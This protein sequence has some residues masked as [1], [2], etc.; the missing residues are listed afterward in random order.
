M[1]D[2][3]YYTENLFSNKPLNYRNRTVYFAFSFASLSAIM[4]VS[5]AP[6]SS[7]GE[8]RMG[9]KST[10]E[11]KNIYQISREEMNYSREAAAEKL[12]FLSSDRIEKIENEKTLPHPE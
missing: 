8:S 7:E 4:I 11:N 12:G 6:M 3:F 2:W 10:K 9:R 5:Y 1:F